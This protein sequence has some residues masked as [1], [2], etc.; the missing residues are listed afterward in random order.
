MEEL[1]V[2][3]RIVQ[4]GGRC[5][6]EI[7]TLQIKSACLHTQRDLSVGRFNIHST[8]SDFIAR[9]TLNQTL[10][11]QGKGNVPIS[12]ARNTVPERSDQS[13]PGQLDTPPTPRTDTPLSF[14]SLMGGVS[15][16]RGGVRHIETC[17][18]HC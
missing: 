3:A 8:P 10:S 16:M 2:D 9:N 12:E 7:K 11:S 4:G 13:H 18:G 14:G 17:S 1:F 6:K 15:H 5:H